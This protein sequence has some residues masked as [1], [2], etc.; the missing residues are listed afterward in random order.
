MALK[1]MFDSIGFS[2][3][4]IKKEK[5]SYL[6][7]KGYFVDSTNIKTNAIVMSKRSCHGCRSTLHRCVSKDSKASIDIEYIS[8][9]MTANDSIVANE[10]Y[11]MEHTNDAVCKVLTQQEFLF[12]IYLKNH[13]PDILLI[14]TTFAHDRD[15]TLTSVNLA[16]EQVMTLLQEVLPTNS[17]TIWLTT[18]ALN[19][20]KITSVVKK[21]KTKEGWTYSQK[22]NALNWI[23][24]NCLKQ[25]ISDPNNSA[26]ANI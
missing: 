8:M 3:K 10:T 16:V 15:A 7:G 2:C 1:F 11:C 4:L 21:R 12:K 24:F 13:Y 25:H 9:M 5:D 20:G 22:I 26:K 18:P 17:K 14:Y 6:P 23:L 19:E